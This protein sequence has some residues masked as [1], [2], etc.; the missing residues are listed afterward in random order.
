MARCK[1]GPNTNNQC[2]TFTIYPVMDG[3]GK[4]EV[5]TDRVSDENENIF[6]LKVKKTPQSTEEPKRHVE[7]ELRTPKAPPP[8]SP[9]TVKSAKQQMTDLPSPCKEEKKSPPEENEKKEETQKKEES[10]KKKKRKKCR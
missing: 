5:H 7:L 4:Q 3:S 10:Q 8:P 2:R 9:V 6:M 1:G